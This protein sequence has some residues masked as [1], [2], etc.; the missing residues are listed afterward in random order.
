MTGPAS[1][2]GYI[3]SAG[4]GRRLGGV[5]KGRVMV[6]GRPMVLRQIDAMLTAGVGQLSLVVGHQASQ[7]IEI[8]QS[9]GC[10]SLSI[11]NLADQFHS[12][13][14]DP[15]LQCSIRHVIKDAV[16]RLTDNGELS[17]ILISLVDLPLLSA[18][19]IAAVI[20]ASNNCTNAVVIP[21]SPTEQPGHPIWLSRAVVMALTL[22]KGDLTLRDVLRGKDPSMVCDIEYLRS[23]GPG[24]FLDLDAPGDID[25]IHRRYNID[26]SMPDRH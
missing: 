20:A 26:I 25:T 8:C 10:P 9:I 23:D 2:L 11:L 13:S 19:D 6:D 21:L 7:V 1:V 22:D 18:D 15:A 24:Y 16:S 14:N 3:L 12:E 5:C 4:R 17:G